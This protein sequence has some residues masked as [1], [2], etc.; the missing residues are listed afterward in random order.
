[1]SQVAGLVLRSDGPE[2]RVWVPFP[3]QNLG[4]LERHFGDLDAIGGALQELLGSS[5]PLELPSFGP[6]R[7]PP[8][9]EMAIASDHA[10]AGLVAMAR[11]YPIASW[12]LRAAGWLAGNPWMAGGHLNLGGRE[13][14]V[15][16]QGNLWIARTEDTNLGSPSQGA[17]IGRSLMLLRLGTLPGPV[18]AGLY[19]LL[20]DDRRV[21][22]TS[23]LSGA[24]YLPSGIDSGRLEE[25]ALSWTRLDSGRE[26]RGCQSL[27]A[28]SGDPTK[29][30]DLPLLVIAET[31]G[32]E[33]WQLPGEPV[34]EAIGVEVFT[35]SLGTWR[36]RSYDA[37]SLRL[38]EDLVAGLET[39]S[40]QV[41]RS[42]IV[43]VGYLDLVEALQVARQLGEAI[44]R[45]PVIG[46]NEARR[47]LALAYLLEQM[48]GIS[49]VSLWLAEPDQLELQFFPVAAD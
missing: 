41:V 45:V 47:W 25:I 37:D 31:A 27:V 20:A 21:V 12:V 32:A 1:M 28:L 13:V 46:E 44:R 30:M 34:F 35:R 36:L 43:S 8:A 14:E 9:T 38:G 16:W 7:V 42:G 11:V 3:H 33:T 10:G 40:R 18:P 5:Q 24:P 49:G 23:S 48:S 39:F 15:E 29:Q 26:T 17:D 19:R 2:I 22:L 6:F 4:S